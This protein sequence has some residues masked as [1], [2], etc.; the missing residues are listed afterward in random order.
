[1]NKLTAVRQFLKSITLILIFAFTPFI[2]A[3]QQ[4]FGFVDQNVFDSDHSFDVNSDGSAYNS[5]QQFI[6]KENRK[7]NEDRVGSFLYRAIDNP[8][9]VRNQIAGSAILYGFDSI[10]LG[11]TV[12][13]GIVFI[14]KNTRF[15]FGECGSMRLKTKSINAKS[16][17][18]SGGV[19]EL[20]SDY[21]FDTMMLEVKWVF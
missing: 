2:Y 7:S 12:K 6:F 4:L 10:G 15:N 11:D 9:K 18:P 20:N 19:L 5:S 17:L 16:C 14:K 13:E 1:M 21:N 3:E 8:D